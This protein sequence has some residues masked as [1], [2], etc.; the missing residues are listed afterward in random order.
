MISKYEDIN[1]Q[2]YNK[3]AKSHAKFNL[4]STLYLAYRDSDMLLKTHLFER[5][6]KKSY[7]VL[8]YGCGTGLSTSIYAQI[9]TE[10]GYELEIIGAD[11][12]NENLTIAQNSIANGKFIHITP[13]QDLKFLGKFD[14]IICNF[15]LVEHPFEEMLDIVKRLQPLLDVTGVLITTNATRQAYKTSNKWYT[16]KNDFQENLPQEVTTSN[17]RLKDDQP[18][19]LAVLDP[20]KKSEM[21]RFYDFFHSG[22]SY[23]KAYLCAGLELMQTHRPLGTLNDGIPWESE[24]DA[25]P[26]KIHV[27]YPKNNHELTPT[28][29]IPLK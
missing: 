24:K 21:F 10:S 29:T 22:K 9:I 14:L 18:V 17:S 8:D 26:Y 2:N 5:L 15:V 3:D 4:N 27:L 16:L 20:V 11:I 1:Q 28:L 6:P 23:Q 25:T 19:S 7:R 12:N 13:D